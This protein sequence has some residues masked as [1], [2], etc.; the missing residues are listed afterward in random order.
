MGTPSLST[1][2]K[3]FSLGI[4][5]ELM[6]IINVFELRELQGLLKKRGN[7]Q[8]GDC[9]SLLIGSTRAADVVESTN[10]DHE[11]VA[12]LLSL[13]HRRV[14]G[15]ATTSKRCFLN[16]GYE[17]IVLT[18]YENVIARDTDDKEFVFQTKAFLSV[19]CGEGD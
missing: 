3:I 15:V 11:K 1:V 4:C 18:T 9:N 10:T 7:C 5:I 14:S 13:P 2:N 8:T 6:A 17:G 16:L 12:S 19:R